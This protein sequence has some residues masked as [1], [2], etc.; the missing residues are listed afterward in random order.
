MKNALPCLL[1]LLGLTFSVVGQELE[2][3]GKVIDSSNQIISFANVVLLQATDSTFVSGTSADEEGSF[4]FSS[5]TAGLYLLQASYV[6]KSSALLAL[7]IQK[8]VTI[9]AIIV[10]FK[11]ESLDE[12]VVTARQPVVTRKQ[13]RLVFQVENTVVSQGSSWDILRSTP[14]VIVNQSSIEIRGQLP[15]VYLNDRKVQLTGQELKDLLEGLSGTTV[16]AV[17]V[18][19][20]PPAKYDAE[21]GP[22]LNIVTNKNIVPGY[23]GS[24]N[25]SYTQAIFPKYTFGTN[26]FYKT[27]KWNLFGEYSIS[28]KRETLSL[29]KGIN[30]LNNQNEL[31]SQ[32]ETNDNQVRNSTPQ[33]VRA[34]VD[35]TPNSKHS[36]GLNTIV[37]LN[38]NRRRERNLV[39]E[40]RNAQNTIDSTFSTQNSSIEDTRNLAADF[41][42][43]Y[44]LNEKGAKLS[45]N[46]HYTLFDT[47]FEQDIATTYRGP[48]AEILRNFAFTTASEQ[49]IQIFTGQ[50]DFAIPLETASLETGLKFSTVD[51]NSSIDFFDLVGTDDNV[52][53][54]LADD[55]LYN[56]IVYA[57]YLSYFKNWEKWSAKA[58]LRGELTDAE[59]NSL[60]LNQVNRQDFF[61]LFPSLNLLYSPN[62]N[63][64][65]AFDYGRRVSRPQYD[66]LNPFRFFF[67]ENDFEEG[68]PELQPVF[69]NNFNL[70]YSL[71]SEYFFDLYFR[72]N[73]NTISQLVFQ[74]NQNQV[75]REVKQNV[76]SSFS[77]G[78]D[79]T[80]SKS[81]LDPWFIYSYISLFHEEDT[82]VAAES[83]N[84][85]FTN[86]LDAFYIYLANYLTLSGD[87]TFTGELTFSYFSNFLVGSFIQEPTA[88]LTIGL[89]KS[90][91][92][93]RATVSVA[94]ED[95]LGMANGTF[96]SQFLNQN[97]SFLTQPETRFVR[98]G[99]T[100]NFGNFRLEDNKKSIDKKER[101]RLADQ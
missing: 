24:V 96:T 78:L 89:R 61:Q 34:T 33:T 53:E 8:D 97:N 67:N 13:D 52:D 73:G 31:F 62:E 18:I 55:F 63:H 41:T 90:L 14:G 28:P 83:G 64:S 6:G 75:L 71:K 76:L 10:P 99:F 5:V 51:S 36:F 42:Y 54:S 59:G 81:I 30:F 25:A 50:L 7:D 35:F 72:D 2:L 93:N 32:W 26:Q 58:G 45:A 94:A 4:I 65:F 17:E 39:A 3:K 79:F 88:N 9:G 82:F 100:Y 47:G 43:A 49:D 80:V 91:W 16:Q 46:A 19:A 23:K 74:D 48:N 68:N 66:D 20:N 1:T 11:P 21:G 95:L 101:D 15:T 37:S 60:T 29:D 70:N 87:G 56:E 84:V 92:K 38:N 85:P 44:K 22:V 27:E 57:G 98:V 77:Y 12:V 40:I 69:S 86:E